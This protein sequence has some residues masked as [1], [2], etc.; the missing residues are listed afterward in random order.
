MHRIH[1]SKRR[2]E[3]HSN[4]GAV[5]SVWDRLFRSWKAEPNG[6]IVFG[7]DEYQ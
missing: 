1:H 4:Y 5:F 7:V 6:T 3:T 2:E